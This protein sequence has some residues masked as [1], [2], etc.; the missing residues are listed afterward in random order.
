MEQVSFR[1]EGRPVVVVLGVSVAGTGDRDRWRAGAPGETAATNGD[2]GGC[3]TR[4]GN[5]GELH[6]NVYEL[7]Q[8]LAKPRL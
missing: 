7:N 3:R 8:Q 6:C 5:G 1:G 4:D 2:R